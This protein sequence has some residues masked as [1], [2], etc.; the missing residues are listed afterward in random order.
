MSINFVNNKI[1]I[2]GT[3][4]GDSLRTYAASSPHCTVNGRNIVFN[5]SLELKNN[6]NFT[7]QNSSYIFMSDA[8]FEGKAGGEINLTDV[9][10]R[11]D[12]LM[13]LHTFMFPHTQ[14]FTRVTWI[15]GVQGGRSDFFNNGDFTF[16]YNDVS[17]VSYGASDFLHFQTTQTINNLSVINAAGNMIFEPCA[18][19]LGESMTINNLKLVGVTQI[20]GGYNSEGG[21][22]TNDMQ[23][24]ATIWRHDPRNAFFQHVNPIKPSNWLRYE[25]NGRTQNVSE[26][27]THDVKIVKEN[28]VPVE[29][30]QIIL[31]HKANAQ[32][33]FINSDLRY[34]LTTD[35]NGRIPQQ[36]VITWND[37]ISYAD[38][39]LRVVSYTQQIGGGVRDLQNKQIDETIVTQTDPSLTE[40]DKSVVDAYAVISNGNELYD[41]IK[42][43]QVDNYTG[44][45]GP[46]VTRDGAS[47]DLGIHDIRVEENQSAGLIV[48]PSA[49]N[50]GL[51]F[52][53][54][55]S[56]YT[57]D[58]KTT[59]LISG[60]SLNW[61]G[62]REDQNGIIERQ[63]VITFTG[64]VEGSEVRVFSDDLSQELGGIEDSGNSLGVVIEDN[65]VTVVIHHI[66]YEYIRL[67]NV[68]TSADT[69]IPIKQRI[70][71]G[72]RNE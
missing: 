2:E 1:R 53:I 61:I 45:V 49:D 52:S 17:L 60:S 22:I 32:T 35:S 5:V 47:I 51:E 10:V 15:L 12:G 24:E 38:F 31:R 33:S 25:V 14:N 28:N 44:E 23:W 21:C 71:R 29:G 58:L 55:G 54:K 69:T 18:G 67:E 4:T 68:N 3:E 40:T 19:N 27:Y 16:N 56:N 26:Y 46:L 11:Y 66:A 8:K 72:Y 43:Y 70:D 30:S 64:L 34:S 63:K 13:K 65:S 57:G 20:Y 50:D 59:G 41:A 48:A 7:D 36:N 39:D 62:R 37:N 6:Y 42:A 9:V